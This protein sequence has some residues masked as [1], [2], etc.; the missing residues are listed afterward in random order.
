MILLKPS[1]QTLYID[2]SHT[3]YPCIAVCGQ[4]DDYWELPAASTAYGYVYNGSA[5]WKEGWQ[6][7]RGHW[8]CAASVKDTKITWHGTVF[9]VIRLGYLGQAQ[10]GGPIES[11]GRLC[12]ID[13]CSDSL[14]VYPPRLGD[15]S[16]NHL[17]F[18]G[19]VNQSYHIHP[20]IR[21]GFVAGGQ[22][23]ACVKDNS[24]GV[25]SAGDMFCIRERELH[26]F[27][28]QNSHMDIIAFH[29]DGDW[30]PTDQNHTML[31]RT[32]IQR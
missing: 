25:L 22:G 8:F 2:Q 4:N 11:S 19:N 14:L 1:S 13:G 7:T 9:F 17:H 18:P 16:L 12:Y 31:N 32:Y 29:P 10:V 5:Q 26:R 27:T 24:G 30:G 20:S 3:M 15:P 28:T 21:L 23:E 6:I